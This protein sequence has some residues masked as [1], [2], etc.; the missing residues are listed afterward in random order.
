[1][2]RILLALGIFGGFGC[3]GCAQTVDEII[4][5]H[6]AA[7]GLDKLLGVET[8]R[9]A[10]HRISGGRVIRQVLE[11]KRPSSIR[12]SS[13]MGA[14]L[15]DFE[16]S[17]GTSGWK[18]E[19]YSIA[20]MSA[21]RARRYPPVSDILEGPFVNYK[22]KGYSVELAGKRQVRG[23]DCYELKTTT[24]KGAV[25]SRCL[26]AATFLEIERTAYSA[27][28]V[29]FRI[30]IGD[31]H[32]VNGIMFPHLLRQFDQYGNPLEFSVVDDI[33]LDA[34]L[35]DSWF[36]KPNLAAKTLTLGGYLC[37][38]TVLARAI[39]FDSLRG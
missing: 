33:E 9:I 35:N 21:E 7:R 25:E 28:A 2:K 34:P 32:P 13:W 5:K 26:D 39:I 8:V 38:S 10:R 31:H 6:V 22:A 30:E 24:N 15:W 27:G 1:M 4:A 16:S 20:P 36:G 29:Q 23:R 14:F 11:F 37:A 3:I 18:F 19:N 12:N 17:D